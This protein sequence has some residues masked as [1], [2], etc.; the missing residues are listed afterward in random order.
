MRHTVLHWQLGLSQT[1]FARTFALIVGVVRDW[2]HSRFQTDCAA[3]A[4]LQVMAHTPD[5]VKA[6]LRPGDV[7]LGS[8]AEEG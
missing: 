8:P 3:R 2:A 6:A 7:C 1:A 5:A 4:L